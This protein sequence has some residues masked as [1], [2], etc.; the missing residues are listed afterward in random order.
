MLPSPT[1]APRTAWTLLDHGSAGPAVTPAMLELPEVRSACRVRP[2]P[3]RA[4][5]VAQRVR[6][7]AGRPVLAHMVGAADRALR[8]AHGGASPPL[9]V[10]V[11]FDEFP[12]VSAGD[13]PERFGTD[14]FRRFHRVLR[15]AGVPYL[16][17]VLPTVPSRPLDPEA[18]GSRAH[19][20]GER[21]MLDELAADPG[22]ELA[23]HGWT[24]R[25]RDPRPYRHSE[26]LGL[27]PSE[28]AEKLDRGIGV[29]HD[30]G[31]EPRVFVPPHNRFEPRH[32]P[33]FAERFAVVSGGP[34][35][36]LEHGLRPPQWWGDAYW[37]P[38]IQPLYG[39]AAEALAGLDDL[40]ARGAAA[41]WLVITLHL[42]WELDDDL[43]GLRAL[44]DRLGDGLARP[45]SDLLDA[46]DRTR[47]AVPG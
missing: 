28:V 18:T 34:E 45:W 36:A 9:R 30:H 29:L 13:R 12:C 37:L 2:V 46:L 21:A 31:V 27:T 40:A 24:H 19:D 26:L 39:T 14:A 16:C 41:P 10:L 42:G 5:R 25:V 1:D 44:A 17:A 7:K 11:R 20:A 47:T 33:V 22:V 23:V 3:P 8:A 6:E 32:W 38:S 15:D 4:V 35:S 43:A